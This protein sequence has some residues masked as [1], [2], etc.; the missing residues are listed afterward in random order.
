MPSRNATAYA[1]IVIG[2]LLLLAGGA[3]ALPMVG[4][5]S[6]VPDWA[7][8]LLDWRSGLYGLPGGLLAYIEFGVACIPGI[9]VLS[10]GLGLRGGVPRVRSSRR[11]TIKPNCATT[12]SS[13]PTCRRAVPGGRRRIMISE[14]GDHG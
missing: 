13:I 5:L 8:P 4:P 6:I 11:A 3:L 9:M 1:L 10:I 14:R 12:K 2:A 7:S